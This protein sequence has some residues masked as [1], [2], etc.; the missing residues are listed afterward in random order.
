[1]G[2]IPFAIRS[3]AKAPVLSL[4]VVLSLGL[5]IGGN[6]AIFSLLYQ[7]VLSSLPIPNPERL[8]LLTSPGDLKHGRTSDD[9]DS[10]RSEYVFNWRAFREL[11]KHTEAAD[12]P[13]E[14]VRPMEEQVQPHLRFLRRCWR[15]SGCTA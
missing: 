10:G 14:D 15:C 8:V 6:T 3:L 4:A 5:G 7:V 12:V 2:R 9:D 1:M 13:L 11:E